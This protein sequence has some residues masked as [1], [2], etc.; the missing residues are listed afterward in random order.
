MNSLLKIQSIKYKALSLKVPGETQK[1]I[2]HVLKEIE[3]CL[4][5]NLGQVRLVNIGYREVPQD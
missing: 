2:P 1:S 5:I 4:F 3:N